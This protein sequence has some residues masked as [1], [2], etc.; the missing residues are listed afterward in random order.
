MQGRALVPYT[1]YG[2]AQLWLLPRERTGTALWARS[3][4][5]LPN[6]PPNIMIADIG[7]HGANIEVDTQ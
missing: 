5:L 7:T 2:V 4:P 6:F 1:W 3:T